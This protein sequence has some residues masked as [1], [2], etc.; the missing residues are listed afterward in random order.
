MLI[1]VISKINVKN[2]FY[3]LEGKIDEFAE[4]IFMK[5]EQ[6]SRTTHRKRFQVAFQICTQ[7]WQE[8]MPLLAE[9]ALNRPKSTLHAIQ[10]CLLML[11]AK[12]AA[13][14]LSQIVLARLTIVPVIATCC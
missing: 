8:K 10:T 5:L 14:R 7:Y 9:L 1:I 11:I 6:N 2:I 12:I 4:T 3:H 13:S